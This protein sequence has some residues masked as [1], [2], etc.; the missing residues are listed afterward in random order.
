[1]S[2]EYHPAALAADTTDYQANTLTR[3]KNAVVYGGQAAVAS[4]AM[5]VYN[6]FLDYAGKDQVNVED[7]LRSYGGND[8][9]DYYAENKNAIDIVGFIGTAIP[10][11]GLGMAGLKLARAG[12][13][14]GNTGKYLNLANSNKAKHL[15][16]AVQETAHAGGV[17]PKFLTANRL[18]HAAWE[19]ADNAILG[20][21][22]EL[23][24][25]ATMNDS[26]LFDQD[27]SGDFAWNIALGTVISGGIG[28]PLGSIAAKGIL[29]SAEKEVQAAARVHDVL[30]DV[31]N[32]GVLAGTEAITMAESLLTRSATFDNIPFR[33]KGDGKPVVTTLESSEA[34]KNIHLSGEKYSSDQL[35]LKFNE[36]AKGNETVGQAYF[37]FMQSA[38]VASKE[39]G[40]APTEIVQKLHGYL[41]SLSHVSELDLAALALDKRKFYLN[42][43]PA[44]AT[45]EER[46][47]SLVSPTRTPTTSKQAYR[48]ADDVS[49]MEDLNIVT[50]E[51]TGHIKLKDV[52]KAQP[53]LDAVQLADGSIRVNNKSTKILRHRENPVT[54][55]QLID[56]E[57]G[58]L[59]NEAAAV[60]GDVLRKGGLT[61]TDDALYING[62]RYEQA[63][64]KATTLADGPMDATA[65][66]AWAAQLD[67]VKFLRISGGAVDA[68]DLPM[69]DRLIELAET[70]KLLPER[71][72]SIKITD[73]GEE[74]F[75][76]ELMN[77]RQFAQQKR[78]DFLATEME[79]WKEA[80]GSVPDTRVLAATLNTNRAWVEA[81]IERGYQLDTAIDPTIGKILSTADSLKP[82]TVQA[83]WNFGSVPDM[84]P[85]AAYNM[86]MGPAN[87]IVK[88]LTAAAQIAVRKDIGV[89]NA[90]MALGKDAEL[91]M[92]AAD[93]LIQETSAQGAGATTFG[94][95]NAGYGQRV[96][97]WSQ[98]TGK[99]TALVSQ[100]RKD[101]TIGTLSPSIN[102][103][104]ADV[105]ASAELGA[106]TTALRKSPFRFV[107][108]NVPAVPATETAQAIPAIN[109]IISLEASKLA[110]QVDETTGLPVGVERALEMLDAAAGTTGK[111]RHS[112]T[113]TNQSAADFLTASTKINTTRQDKFTLLWNAMGLTKKIDSGVVYVPPINTVKYPYHAFVRTKEKVGLASDV[114]MITAKTEEQLRALTAQVKDDY[115]V[116]FK[117][118]TDNYF[119]IKGE[120]DYQHTLNESGVRS[121]LARRGILADFF[122]ETRFENIMDDWLQWHGRQ[123]EKLVRDS[124]QVANRQFFS[125]V[126][127]LSDQYRQVSE[128]VTRGI[129]SRFKARVADPFGDVIKTSLNISKQQEFPLLDSLNDLVDKV[130]LKAGDAINKAFHDSEKGIL[131][132]EDANKVL[133]Q[134]GLGKPYD[135]VSQYLLA[136][137]KFPKN[138]VREIAQKANMVLATTMLRLDFAN[139]LVNM[140]S[141][142]IM[143]GTELASIKGMLK[144]SP[145]EAGKLAE[146]LSMKVPSSELR[147]PGTT[148]L[149]ANSINNYFG[150]D[151]AKLFAR[152]KAIGSIKNV[153]DQY[154]QM[155]DLSAYNPLNN[156]SKTAENINKAVEIGAKITGN[157]FAE[158][159]TRFVSAD[160]MRQLSQPVVDAGK[161]TVR[162]QNAYIST[163]VNK[164]Q[165]NYITSQRPIVFQGTTGAA[166]S[167]FQTYA[168]NVLQQLH[169]HVERGDK[170]TLAIFAGLQ[171]TAFGLN[172]LPFF[173]AANTHL[174]GGYVANNPGHKDAYSV[175]PA[176]NKEL[177]DWM[178]YG[179]ASAFPLLSGSQPAFFTRG[180]INPRHALIL[181][182]AIVDV[183]AVSASIKLVNTVY[184]F[185]KKAAGGADMSDAFLHALE[186][187][188][189]N[190]PLAGFA[191]LLAGQSTDNKGALISANSELLGTSRLAGLVDR[192]V[193]VQG[194]SRLMG[195]RPMDEAVA[196]N[197]VYRNKKYEAMDRSRIERLGEVVRTKLYNNDLPEQDE[198]EDFML[199][200]TRSGGRIE[201]FSQALQRWSR[202]SNVSV[203][204][205][206]AKQVGSPY[207]R[208]LQTIMGGEQLPDYSNA[209]D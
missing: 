68:S 158:D 81:V 143:I 3:I 175:L 104:R 74:L 110:K 159:F 155:L 130:G 152:Y 192:T 40:L 128:S 136:N 193:S 187:Q 78:V 11:G 95:S 186:H 164:V 49:G 165:G 7:A 107:F 129:G 93:D 200:Y 138:V 96:Q 182:T 189:W 58:S 45:A 157:T 204:N 35:A 118:D 171:S 47:L 76:A 120:Y 153:N 170:K 124:V 52:F 113:I 44:G 66:W 209:L 141:T 90:A 160:V 173:D 15:E 8:M 43:S 121:D 36:L 48:L 106:I 132:W 196:L 122:P 146:L 18:K 72:N 32:L 89:R 88:E 84:L 2:F 64:S 33:Y 21:A 102:A 105:A 12:I 28:G 38:I 183:P 27:T 197:A 39:A 29:K 145:D 206:L 87:L 144:N 98:D 119:R 37:E 198:L 162:E 23:A 131:P 127:H 4:G 151:K 205:Q 137:E 82:R 31:S 178:L 135:T 174:I 46:F 77:A 61:H 59:T 13:T 17:A 1:M 60:V 111:Q 161:M 75:F 101:A 147:V 25:L 112:F 125:E 203:V 41:N 194:V 126:Q 57:S 53:E 150:T 56:L 168:F 156:L 184:D 207:S 109:R 177:G 103:L 191:Q 34:L 179:T 26:P 70:G 80:L 55:T 201:N 172:G 24:I 163:F 83:T 79:N 188:G 142:P 63:P 16:Q 92:V 62:K 108:A 167:L 6:T 114:S 19:T 208:K 73:G 180:D 116:F 115:D 140:I 22:G 134:Y 195:A 185:G 5:S 149:I 94:A 42:L 202:D 51:S 133:E 30:K 176:F 91:F 166:V 14:T 181:P 100:A 190:R 65:R 117:A 85:E 9:G 10:M 20:A 139:S 99:N 86:N 123:E 69:L 169:R 54:I 154:H 50:L 67:A 97:L 199:R 71:A 148:H